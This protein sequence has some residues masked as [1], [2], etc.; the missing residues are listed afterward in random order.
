VHEAQ[1]KAFI[2][3]C[4]AC[5]LLKGNCRPAWA[6]APSA[7][8]YSLSLPTMA[9]TLAANPEP[10]SFDAGQFG[11]IYVTGI[12]SGLAQWQTNPGPD[13]TE[14]QVD[15]SNAQLFVQKADGLLQFFIQAGFY[16]Q[17]ALGIEYVNAATTTRDL[18]GPLP[19][20]FVK[21]APTDDWSIMA[22]QL[23]S[24]EGLEQTFT[25]QNMN[26][27]RGLLWNQSSSVSRGV[28]VNHSA[29]PFSLALS[30][31]DGYYSGR[32]S[33]ISGSASW[34]VDSSDSL[35]LVGAA[36]AGTTIIS[37]TATPVLQN[38][39]QLYNVIYT[40]TSGPWTLIPYLQYTYL[41]R[42]PSI[43][44]LHYASTYGAALLASYVFG[45]TFKAGPLN[46]AG[47]SL[48]FRLEYI[49]STGSVADRAPNLLYGPGSSAWSITLTP[50]YQYKKFFTRV[51]FSYVGA[52][53]T[54]AG[55][56]FGAK[57][58]KTNQT[59]LLLEWGFLF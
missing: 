32:F 2:I 38:N 58:S 31:N 50:T 21:L 33:W 18:W 11:K 29:G 4:F 20:A 47:F 30:W 56:A 3:A 5:A 24:L 15:L 57:G 41:P 39:S 13:D 36:N 10:F 35:S 43:G 46:L 7:T 22:G 54:A 51:E 23:S 26:V 14:T 16:S 1:K 49:T 37:K 34:N 8:A 59:R 55:A 52:N 40:R 45:S 27:E 53:D 19:L 12:V 28:Q 9:G 6:Q 17:P 42:T 25:F 44:A 48:P